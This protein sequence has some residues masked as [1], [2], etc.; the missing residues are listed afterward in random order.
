MVEYKALSSNPSTTKKKKK[1]G[2]ARDVKHLAKSGTVLHNKERQT[3]S[4]EGTSVKTH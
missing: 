4:V 2:G 3:P 1:V